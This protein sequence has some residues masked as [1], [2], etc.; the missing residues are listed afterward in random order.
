M[1][2]YDYVPYIVEL[3]SNIKVY[4]KPTVYTAAENGIRCGVSFLL[5]HLK[6]W[7]PPAK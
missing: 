3:G 1:L 2:T 7:I 4:F 6:N 5:I